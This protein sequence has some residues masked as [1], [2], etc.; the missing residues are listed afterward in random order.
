MAKITYTDKV[1]GSKF[2]A[3]DANEIKTSVNDLYDEVD[4]INEDIE[5]LD[6][7]IN[8]V[9][10]KSFGAVGDAK[11]VTDAVVTA[12]SNL[13]TSATANFSSDDIGKTVSI[14]YAGADNGVLTIGQ[15]LIATITGINS[16]SIAIL[17]VEAVKSITGARSVTDASITAGSNTLTS[18]TAAF[19]STDIGKRVI[20]NGA[21]SPD[22]NTTAPD[23]PQ[24][25]YIYKVLSATQ[26]LVNRFAVQTVTG[27]TANISGAWAQWGTD[28]TT[29]LQAAFDFAAD[30]KTQLILDTGRYL[31]TDA[32]VPKSNLYLKGFGAGNSIIAPVGILDISAIAQSN[33]S[34]P[35]ADQTLSDVRLEDFEIDGMGVTVNTYT[36]RNKGLYIRP[37]LRPVIK[38]LY[39]HNTSATGIGVDFL[40]DYLIEGNIV[41]HC[42]RQVIELGGIGGNDS[43]YAGGSGIGIGSGLFT[44]ESGLIAGNIATDCGNFGIFVEGQN[45]TVKSTGCKIIGNTA[46]W[47]Q[48]VG[49]GDTGCN[50]TIV[51]ENHI[52]FNAMGFRSTSAPFLSPQ[53]YSKNGQYLNNVIKNN[54]NGMLIVG[55]EMGHR[56]AGNTINCDFAYQTTDGIRFYLYSGLTVNETIVENNRLINCGAKGISLEAGD[57]SAKFGRTMISKNIIYNTGA[58]T[59]SKK[60]AIISTL[61][62]ADLIVVDNICFD[63]R[64]AGSKTQSYGLLTSSGTIDAF[65]YWNNQFKDNADGADS[66]GGTITARYLKP[67]L[68]LANTWTALNTYTG[69]AVYEG[70]MSIDNDSAFCRI[71]RYSST[72]APNAGGVLITRARGTKSSPANILTGDI[73]GKMQVMGRVSG[74]DAN[75]G[76]LGFTATDLSGNGTWDVYASDLTTIK[77]SINNQTGAISGGSFKLSAL[78]T[79]P[80]T[81]TATGTLGEIRYT[82]THIYVCTATNTWVRA[83]LATW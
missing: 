46:A 77:A 31:T 62:I 2:T 21:G 16:D 68:S 47:N 59:A 12:G 7:Q 3:G 63:T 23:A 41:H 20:I 80:A 48:L 9:T 25:C 65:T 67:D 6:V 82:A 74:S 5:E 70:N 30:N 18:A 81:A 45:Q 39:I 34:T 19:T 52:L 49:I 22:N 35:T 13:L 8:Y 17:S 44:E 24:P 40:Q 11:F 32:L 27:A 26:V 15:S 37:M 71:K 83:A 58:S 61:N 64:T 42:G 43:L 54:L 14:P 55:Q 73:L 69:D 4:S 36:T 56:V 79:A 72:G 33:G 60:P 1:I 28:D 51:A 57:G 78:N 76:F 38:G 10:A 66:L 50:G 53:S 29:T 75:Y